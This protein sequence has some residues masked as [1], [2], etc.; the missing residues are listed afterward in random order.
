MTGRDAFTVVLRG[1]GCYLIYNALALGAYLA[2]IL[3][4]LEVHLRNEPSADTFVMLVYLASGLMVLFKADA[5][6]RLIYKADE[7]EARPRRP[8]L[9][10]KVAD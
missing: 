3:A 8:Q 5:I 2:A 9:Q 6:S 10:P 1:F 7:A 4:H